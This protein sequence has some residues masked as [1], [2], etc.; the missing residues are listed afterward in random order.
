[1]V[2][3]PQ[4]HTVPCTAGSVQKYRSPPAPSAT[5][6]A[7]RRQRGRGRSKK[8][9][10]SRKTFRGGDFDTDLEKR[11]H[12]H[13]IPPVY[14]PCAKP[15]QCTGTLV[16]PQLA[17]RN[18]LRK[19]KPTYECAQTAHDW[20]GISGMPKGGTD[21]SKIVEFSFGLRRIRFAKKL[22]PRLP[23][24]KW[25]QAVPLGTD[26]W[27]PRVPLAP[28][29][30]VYCA[31]KQMVTQVGLRPPQGPSGVAP[32]KRGFFSQT[33]ADLNAAKSSAVGPRKWP[34]G[35]AR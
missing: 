29:N 1:M 7:Y 25:A 21:S 8:S 23:R 19:F 31:W 28:G 34:L 17:V 5:A 3:S 16:V 24:Y 15:P 11:N 12:P 6:P 33:H 13:E 2:V 10:K 14:R 35:G 26:G 18:K 32:L 30:G 4:V 22:F 27:A 9:P 20:T